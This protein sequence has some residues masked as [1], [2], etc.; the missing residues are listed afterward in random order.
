MRRGLSRRT[1]LALPAR[2][3]SSAAAA[4]IPAVSLDRDLLALCRRFM[5]LECRRD[6]L[7]AWQEA[8]DAEGDQ[9][10]CHR[11]WEAQVRTVPYY[12]HLLP[13]IMALPAQTRQGLLAKAGVACRRIQYQADLEPKSDGVPLW[14]LCRDL[15]GEAHMLQVRR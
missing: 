9:A 2:L 10:L 14:S 13:E 4:S 3:A 1:A 12:Q 7:L 11:I 8:A 15:L 5:T 6:R